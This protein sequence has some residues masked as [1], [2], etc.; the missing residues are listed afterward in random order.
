MMACK[1][2]DLWVRFREQ[3]DMEA[4]EELLKKNIPLVRF[5]IE[6]MTVPQNRSWLD[7]DDLMT[8]GIIG[9]IDAVGKFNPDRGGKFSTY[10]FFRIRGAVLDEMRSMDWVPRSVRQKTRELEQAYEHLNNKLHRPVTDQ[11]LAKHFKMSMKRFQ[12]MLTDINIPPVISLDEIMEDREKKRRDI[13]AVETNPIERHFGGAFTELAA[14]EAR[15]LLGTM[16]ERLP[17]KERLVLTL[18]YY[19][20]LTLKE[21]AAILE[22]TESRICQ[23]HGQA[24]VHLRTAMKAE[25]MDFIIK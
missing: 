6:R 19:E 23:I 8:A 12:S 10:A 16:I 25:R 11:D 2:Q 17:E 15:D 5:T 4:R 7:L 1:D 3:N 20:E 13:F 18:Y 21:I 14:K 9:L 24:V 22:V